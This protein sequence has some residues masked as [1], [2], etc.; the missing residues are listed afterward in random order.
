M[1]MYQHEGNPKEQK[2]PE[3]CGNCKFYTRGWCHRFPPQFAQE[4]AKWYHPLVDYED[5]CGEWKPNERD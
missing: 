4:P 2:A 3:N 5:W 1:S